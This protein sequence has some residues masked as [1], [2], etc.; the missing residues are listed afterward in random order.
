MCGLMYINFAVLIQQ[1]CFFYKFLYLGCIFCTNRV[2][3]FIDLSNVM[4]N[5]TNP[6]IQIVDRF[7][8]FSLIKHIML[9]KENIYSVKCC[10]AL[11]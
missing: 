1:V 8:V 10:E 3:V 5:Y 7:P 9:V 2:V 6:F 4:S 11:H